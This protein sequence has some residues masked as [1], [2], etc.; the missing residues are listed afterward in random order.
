MIQSQLKV[1]HI[2]IAI[3]LSFECFDLIVDALYG[4]T[5][6]TASFEGFLLFLIQ[7]RLLL[8]SE[9]INS[10]ID[11]GGDMIL[12][13][14]D[15][16]MGDMGLFNKWQ[17][18]PPQGSAVFIANPQHFQQ[19]EGGA[20]SNRSHPIPSQFRAL[21]SNSSTAGTFRT[22]LQ[23]IGDLWMENGRTLL[24]PGMNVPDTLK[25]K[26]MTDPWIYLSVCFVS[27]KEDIIPSC[28]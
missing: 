4:T 14:Y 25:A 12:I 27:P 13:K 1:V 16:H 5:R 7:L 3:G 6:D 9:L 8:C 19:S 17:P 23:T 22:S 28:R 10:F 18:G 26:G 15:S 20:A 11:Q 21:S 24:V 2:T